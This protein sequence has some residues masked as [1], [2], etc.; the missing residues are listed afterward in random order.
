MQVTRFSG[1]VRRKNDTLCSS[2]TCTQRQRSWRRTTNLSYPTSRTRRRLPAAIASSGVGMSPWQLCVYNFS[3]RTWKEREQLR[4]RETHLHHRLLQLH[5]LMRLAAPTPSTLR[6]ESA[7][8]L[9][10]WMPADARQR[11]WLHRTTASYPRCIGLPLLP[12]RARRIV[13]TQALRL[14]LTCSNCCEHTPGIPGVA[15][16]P[17]TTPTTLVARKRRA[18]SQG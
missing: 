8:R 11:D 7:F 16:R 3:L 9:L 4:I 5:L 18:L 2:S 15:F 6:R 13:S 12:S 17:L 10:G 1:H 14:M